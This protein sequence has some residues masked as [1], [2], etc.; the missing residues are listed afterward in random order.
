N[1][2]CRAAVYEVPLTAAEMIG[3]PV[4]QGGQ[5]AP[6]VVLQLAPRVGH[7]PFAYKSW[8]MLICWVCLVRAS[9]TRIVIFTA[10]MRI[11]SGTRCAWAAAGGAGS[12]SVLS[13]LTYS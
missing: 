8:M 5:L 10:R 11:G 13:Q 12:T 6:R 9:Q 4:R 1:S 3:F 7:P 2:C